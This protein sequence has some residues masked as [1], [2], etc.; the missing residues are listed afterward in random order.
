MEGL[1]RLGP[2]ETEIPASLHIQ[3]PQ[4]SLTGRVRCLGHVRMCG[5][6]TA[7]LLPTPVG[8]ACQP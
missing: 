2:T 5:L 7:A 4:G 8:A 6:V 3:I 1:A